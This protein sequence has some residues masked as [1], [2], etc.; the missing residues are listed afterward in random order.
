MN[1]LSPLN[2]PIGDTGLA[3]LPIFIGLRGRIALLIGGGEGVL[4]KLDLLRRA[5]AQVRLVAPQL[6]SRVGQTVAEDRMIVHVETPLAIAHFEDVTLAIDASGDDGVN[7]ISTRLARAARVPINVVDRPAFCDFILPAIL[8]RSP[9]VVAVSTGGLAPAVARLIRQRLETAIP[10]GF[11][12]IATLG[13]GL[14]RAVAERLPSAG[15]RAAFWEALFNGPAANLA[16]AGQMDDARVLA[17]TL[18]D[19]GTEEAACTGTIHVLQVTSCDPDLLTVRAAR[20]IRTADL[21][22][23]EPTV[24]PGILELG[25][26]DALKVKLLLCAGDTASRRKSLNGL[27]KRV[28]AG[29]MAVHLAVAPKKCGGDR[30]V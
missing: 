16:L 14:R 27:R 7:R 19:R 22:A 28:G 18:I 20:L 3:Y 29:C 17:E 24:A 26:R 11:G 30:L 21:I 12:R 13:A 1:A 4:A 25:R 15:Q 10:A 5:G 9:I 8:D 6:D 2:K 23:Y